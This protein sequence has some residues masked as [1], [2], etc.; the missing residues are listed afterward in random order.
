ML[1]IIVAHYDNIKLLSK[2][3]NSI[4]EQDSSNIHLI[5]CQMCDS[6]ES[7]QY[8]QKQM[9]IYPDQITL[10]NTKRNSLT[11][12]YQG[13]LSSIESKYVLFA[14]SGDIFDV[15]GLKKSLHYFNNNEEKFSILSLDII[16]FESNVPSTI[17]P[18]T[19]RKSKTEILIDLNDSPS[20]VP[21]HLYGLIFL[22]DALKQYTIDITDIKYDAGLIGVYRI[23]ADKPFIGYMA[24]V[25]YKCVYVPES[26]TNII[27]EATEKD[28]YFK[29]LRELIIPLLELNSETCQSVPEFIQYAAIY[30]LK[31]RY[32]YNSD[33]NNKHVIDNEVEE[34]N[35]LCSTI[36][37]H[38]SDR[39]IFNLSLNPK[40]NM[41]RPLTFALLYL[42]YD[43]SYLA[44]FY[45]DN[46]ANSLFMILNKEIHIKLGVPKVSID[47]LE[48]SNE[49][50]IIEA[51]ADNFIGMEQ[52]KLY[53][54]LN[55]KKID[56][57]E[58]YHYAHSKFFGV[59]FHKRYTFR[60]T[61]PMKSFNKT[62]NSLQFFY[63]YQFLYYKEEQI[64]L[65]LSATTY[66]AKVD[67][68]V[69]DAY[70][71]LNKHPMIRYKKNNRIMAIDNV[72][73]FQ[74]VKQEIKMLYHMHTDKN[75]PRKMLLYRLVY[76]LTHPF[77]KHKT[78][79]L[80]YDKLYKGGDCGEYLYRYMCTRKDS[81]TP[82]YVI[83][84]SSP[85][86]KKLVDEGYKPLR[87]GS[88]KHF[89][90]Y[91]N[92]SVVFTTHGGVHSFNALTN[93]QVRYVQDRIHHDVACIQH[94]LT[95]QQLAFNSHRLYNNMKR[96]YCAS[97]Y[98]IKNLS[99]PIYGYEDK[100]ILKL[101]GIPRYDGLTNQDKKQI[102]ITPTWRSYIAMPPASKNSAIPYNPDFVHTDYFKIYNQLL[103]NEKLIKTAKENGYKLIYLLH[104]VISAQIGD[105]PKHP[106][107]EILPATD[108]NYEKILTESSLMI[109]DYSG[110]QF[111]FAYMR[112]P[113]V[114]YHPPELPPH[115]KE[116]GFFY[117]SMGFGE[118][119]TKHEL[120]VNT[121]CDYLTNNCSV[122]PF[123]RA[124]QDDFF[125]YSDLNSCQRIYDDMLEFQNIKGR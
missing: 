115:Y 53:P 109:T 34:F 79:W 97:K 39:I 30:Q 37:K 123:Y 124:R 8:I 67:T 66:N 104:P 65:T 17:F 92:S 72:S 44:D 18:K 59:S 29:R 5:I 119:C 9:T 63:S 106:D 62:N 42:K 56:I 107:V 21:T 101:T 61:I 84:E 70:W 117:D 35:Q 38:I 51:S 98:E 90:Y 46:K 100:D 78:I 7:D 77:M 11:E 122:K 110:V 40:Y 31:W 3:L 13:V 82:A 58:T 120:L 14:Q 50:L 15:L 24:N 19:L 60:L 71:L 54:V 1:S 95:V 75:N 57:E 118:I 85:D 48:W 28:W 52:L 103:S 41:S 99:H 25:T 112:K 32:T 116:S 26:T 20:C 6:K 69:Q 94:G 111:D 91:I 68:R 2:T 45:F 33:N 49:N 16:H 80:T 93:G 81:I 87:Y 108:I 113:V 102:L 86:Y 10:K 96:Y 83:N 74:K 23:L 125:A 89:L 22:T 105:Y 64:P 47:L 27:E 114:Y 55:G 12:A 121:L 4:F 73:V 88:L 36:L 43:G 76:W